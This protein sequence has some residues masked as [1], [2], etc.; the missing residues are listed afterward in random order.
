MSKLY[1]LQDVVVIVHA[2]WDVLVYFS[3]FLRPDE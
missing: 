2:E 3:F 1:F